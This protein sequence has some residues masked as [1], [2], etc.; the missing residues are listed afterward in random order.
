MQS[1]QDQVEEAERRHSA[2]E[3]QVS[4]CHSSRKVS[5]HWLATLRENNRTNMNN[6]ASPRNN[7]NCYTRG[8]V[9]LQSY[10]FYYTSGQDSCTCT[11]RMFCCAVIM[12]LIVQLNPDNS[13]LQGKSKKV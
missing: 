12:I 10:E 13:N 5:Y 9:E 4:W 2:V 1:L 6:A 8:P 11:I 3:G 7:S